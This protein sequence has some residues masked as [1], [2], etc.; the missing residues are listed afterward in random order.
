[1]RAGPRRP[2]GPGAAGLAVALG[3]A[4]YEWG[5]APVIAALATGLVTSASPPQ[6]EGLERVVELTRS[7]REQP[8]PELARSAQLS[9][10]SAIS[11]NERLQYQLHPW[12]SYVIV[13]LFA[14]ANAG[15]HVTGGLLTR[16]VSSPVTLGIVVGYVVGKAVG[17]LG[18]EWLGSRSRLG[19]MR[20]TLSWPALAGGGTVAGIGFTVSLLISSIAFRGAHL[21]EAKVGVLVAAVLATFLA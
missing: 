14:L 13:P 6:R 21:E 3:G 12:T 17:M 18:G 2:R 16:A 15:I 4:V 10:A 7:F 1:G 9:V 19:G 5:I 11:P 20:R 8:T